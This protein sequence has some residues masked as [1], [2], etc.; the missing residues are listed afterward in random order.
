MQGP[1]K[2]GF[3]KCTNPE[4]KY[5]AIP[6]S[7][8]F[9]GKMIRKDRDPKCLLHRKKNKPEKQVWCP[10]VK[11]IRSFIEVRSLK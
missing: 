8:P 5:I 9:F 6:L 1:N 2:T 7:S 11:V 10:A 4:K 3:Q